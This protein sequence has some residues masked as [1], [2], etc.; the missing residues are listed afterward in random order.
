MLWTYLAITSCVRLAGSCCSG[1][2]SW[3]RIWGGL[4]LYT[5][6]PRSSQTCLIGLRSGE[7]A[8][9]SSQSMF[10]WQQSREQHDLRVVWCCH[11]EI[12]YPMAVALEMPQW[13]AAKSFPHG[14]E[15]WCCHQWCTAESFDSVN[16]SPNN[17]SPPTIPVMLVKDGLTEVQSRGC[18]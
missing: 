13:A 10:S 3:S 16:A 4:T 11:L 14:A 8:G 17:Y 9:Q 6:L 2:L 15:P 1:C 7:L 18:W 12:R 5:L